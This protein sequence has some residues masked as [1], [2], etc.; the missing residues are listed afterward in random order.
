[1]AAPVSVRL[2]MYN[3]GFG[4]CFLL[5][6]AY[7]GARATKRH[8]LID[9][10]S[11]SG[12]KVKTGLT[13]QA[14][15]HDIAAE[16]G[17]KLDAVI[18]TH[19]HNDHINGFATSKDGKG[20]GDVIRKLAPRVVVQPWTSAPP[21][22]A[23]SLTPTL[24]EPEEEMRTGLSS[25]HAVARAL[26]AELEARPFR[27]RPMERAQVRFLA[28]DNRLNESAI[29]NLAAMGAAGAA[30]YL[31]AGQ[32]SAGLAR[33][34][35]GVRFSILGPASP[36]DETEVG[37]R[38]TNDA[39]AYWQLQARAA[40]ST[41]GKRRPLPF[42]LATRKPP[43]RVRW[44]MR[45]MDAARGQQL[46]GVA[47]A[48]DRAMNNTSLIVLIQIGRARLLFPGDAQA[49][50]WACALEAPRVGRELAGVDLY[51]VGH[52]G[53][54]D[55]TPKALWRALTSQKDRRLV[56][57]LSTKRGVHG[58]SESTR[59]PRASLVSALHRGSELT[60]TVG[61]DGK[62]LDEPWFDVTIPFER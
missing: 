37:G 50:S 34:V 48:L 46:L 42:P 44:I 29:R 55:A 39:A 3:V 12:A 15:A 59:V 31:R 30:E 7:P 5:S 47:R 28:D 49:E 22:S 24:S 9:F 45:Q 26:H 10:G 1:M 21:A 16:T 52:H 17:G 40:G 14:I 25:A 56:T 54:L 13:L 33:A 57:V 38:R 32:R 41:M 4:D 20:P 43:P 19:R 11:A 2:R 58:T 27:F 61:A 53:S 62:T 23:R 51:K 6:F 60:A 18:A 36:Q 35:P 8:L